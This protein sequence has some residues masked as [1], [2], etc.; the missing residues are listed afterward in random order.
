MKA[1]ILAAVLA[2]SLAPV[3]ARAQDAGAAPSSLDTSRLPKPLRDLLDAAGLGH[4]GPQPVLKVESPVSPKSATLDHSDLLFAQ[5]VRPAVAVRLESDPGPKSYGAAGDLLWLARGA[6]GEF[7]CRNGAPSAGIVTVAGPRTYCFADRNRD[8]AFDEL[9]E[10]TDGLQAGRLDYRPLGR[11]VR[12]RDEVAYAPAALDLRQVVGVAYNGP[13][14]GRIV[15][16]RLVDG[17]V[18][19]ELLAGL[20]GEG[21]TRLQ[22]LT[23]R[24][25]AEGKGR[26]SGASG[27]AFLV[28]RVS[29]D[30]RADVR[31]L[32][33]FLTGEAQLIPTP[34]LDSIRQTFGR[35][36]AGAP[37]TPPTNA[38]SP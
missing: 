14:D 1:L 18:E 17:E 5:A 12:L 27:L 25:D 26:H 38:P 4:G 11:K 6:E 3:Q 23:V 22:R 16:G 37:S 30:G 36:A 10:Q 34:T 28:E 32:S 15:E 20:E 7:Y 9:Y 33:G 35:S 2:A 21:R 19:F 8:G 24:L 13:V 29:A 31:L